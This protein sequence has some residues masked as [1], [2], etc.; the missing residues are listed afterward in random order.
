MG[1]G[2]V[3]TLHNQGQTRSSGAPNAFVRFAPHFR[4]RGAVCFQVIGNDGLGAQCGRLKRSA[5]KANFD[6]GCVETRAF[7]DWA[8]VIRLA[9]RI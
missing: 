7:E 5:G 8:A 1:L 2:R 6:P 4:R 9:L 3:E